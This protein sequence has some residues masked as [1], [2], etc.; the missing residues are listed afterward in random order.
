MQQINHHLQQVKTEV[1]T[2][3]QAAQSNLPT[4]L[5]PILG[6]MTSEEKD[7]YAIKYAA[8]PIKDLPAAE[9]PK[10]AKALIFRIHTISGWNVPDDDFFLNAL[11]SEF[12]KLLTESYK[13]LN[14]EEIAYAVRNYG[15]EVKDWGKNM[16]LSLIDKP[17]AEYRRVR[18]CLSEVEERKKSV[19]G[20]TYKPTEEELINM[21]RQVVE[22]RYQSFLKGQSSFVMQPAD[23]METLAMD[24]F[25]QEDLY[26]DF[27][28][29]ACQKVKHELGTEREKLI[30]QCNTAYAE[31]KLKE[32]Q[33]TTI[34]T[35]GVVI[36]AKKMAL[37][38]CF[39]Q[40][41]KAGFPHIYQPA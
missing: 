34:E 40:F 1:I 38:Y 24:F 36:L 39:L 11:V 3:S 16:N 18:Q 27:L 8:R 19:A 13:D 2:V 29:D 32:I 20:I 17:I 41:K 5:Q 26:K 33:E 23:G 4:H 21:R 31:D 10:Y 9:L 35:P 6:A 7:M 22:Q 15:L 12:T 37:V 14:V 25:C 28:E 30:M